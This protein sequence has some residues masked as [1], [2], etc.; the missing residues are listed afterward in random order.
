MRGAPP[1]VELRAGGLQLCRVFEPWFHT[2]VTFLTT[3][4]MA[5]PLPVRK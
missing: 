5:F 3:R 2:R 1:D 4:I